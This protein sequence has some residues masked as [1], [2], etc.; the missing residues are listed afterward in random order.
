MNEPQAL[1]IGGGISGLSTAWHLAQQ[2]V[3]VEV[4][5]ADE[6]PGGKIRSTHDAGYLTERAAGMV[7]NF[8]P[9]IDRL[10]TALGMDEDKTSRNDALNRYL[11]HKGQLAAVP[12]KLPAMARSPLWSRRTKLRLLAE[13]LIPQGGKENETVSAFIE[14]RLGS[15]ILETAMEPFVAGT[16]ASDPDLAEARSVLPRLTALEKRYGSLTLGMLINGIFKRRRANNAESFSFQG[17]LSDLVD[18]LSNSAGVNIRYN[19]KVDNI[20][21]TA[22]GWQVTAGSQKRHTPQLILSTPAYTAATLLQDSDQQLARLL[23]GIDYSPI[24]VLHFGLQETKI[25]HPLDGT[26]FLVPRREPLGFNGNLWMSRLFPGRAPTGHHLL[27]S[28]LGGHRHR[29]QLQWSDERI[30]SE[31]L[32]NLAP[33]LGIRGEPDYIRLERHQRGLPMYHGEYQARVTAIRSRLTVAA[34]GLH[35][36]ANY[37]EGVSI[38]ERIFQGLKTAGHVHSVL[39][40]SGIVRIDAGE[41]L[42]YA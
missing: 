27:T 30:I 29:H 20:G 7:V 15:E 19:M 10:I 41:V 37:L 21:R 22:D 36:C 38:R 5:E 12:M 23:S 35:L 16:L 42:H 18:S 4:W 3:N 17:G 32:S 14:R 2:G 28:Y 11:M 9:E 40:K 26:G 39:K 25:S 6:R 13:I 33:L 24:G 1:I 8:R 31:T 34:P